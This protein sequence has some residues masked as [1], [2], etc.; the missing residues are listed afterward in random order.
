MLLLGLNTVKKTI[1]ENAVFRFVEGKE[2][3]RRTKQTYYSIKNVC[4][5]SEIR[6]KRKC[7]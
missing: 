1:F 3:I 2:K 5:F 4:S 6:I 7:T